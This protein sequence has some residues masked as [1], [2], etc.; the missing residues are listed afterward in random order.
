M[1]NVNEKI[2]GITNMPIRVYELLKLKLTPENKLD[3][4]L[5]VPNL[6]MGITDI[7]RKSK[8]A[9]Q[10]FTASRDAVLT[11]PTQIIFKS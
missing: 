4:D 11:Y 2:P 5:Y 8:T 7:N 1:R 10:E 9:L 3:E 6:L